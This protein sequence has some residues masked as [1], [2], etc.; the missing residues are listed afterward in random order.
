M[1]VTTL[2]NIMIMIK[3]TLISGHTLPQTRNAPYY[4]A[5]NEHQRNPGTGDYAGSGIH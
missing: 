3:K 1:L 4:S 5:F 2:L